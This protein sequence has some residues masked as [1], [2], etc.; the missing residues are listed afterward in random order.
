MP[1]SNPAVA[2]AAAPPVAPPSAPAVGSRIDALATRIDNLQRSMETAS[3][4]LNQLNTVVA[5]NQVMPPA[6]NQISPALEDRLN[7]IEQSL[8]QIEHNEAAKAPPPAPVPTETEASSEVV[9]KVPATHH[10]KSAKHKPVHK[11]TVHHPVPVA[12][13]VPVVTATSPWVLRAATPNE[14]WVA[15]DAQSAELRHVQVGDSLS[16][17]GQIRSIRHTPDGWEIEGTTGTIR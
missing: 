3:Q 5:A 7:K 10:A 16:G 12:A 9:T 6:S 8:L 17:I 15:A 2:A 1:P 11:K 4:Q 13:R 14:A